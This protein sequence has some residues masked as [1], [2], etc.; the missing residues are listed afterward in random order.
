QDAHKVVHQLGQALSNN[1][2]EKLN[3]YQKYA[4]R[5]ENRIISRLIENIEVG[6]NMALIQS[7]RILA[8]NAAIEMPRVSPAPD[9]FLY[10][11]LFA[12][13]HFYLVSVANIR[14]SIGKL[15]KALGN[16][17]DDINKDYGD[18]FDAAKAVRNSQEH[19]DERIE[20]GKYYGKSLNE[21][22]WVYGNSLAL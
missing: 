21:E 13:I 12:D 11:K 22:D 5:I 19:L 14:K 8:D 4:S 16:K 9:A 7:E 17:L 18:F 20:S 1:N 3:S 15:D 6:V 10:L 2:M